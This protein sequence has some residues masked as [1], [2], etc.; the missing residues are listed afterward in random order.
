MQIDLRVLNFN[1]QS[2]KIKRYL[3][4]AAFKGLLSQKY[5]YFNV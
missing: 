3:R 1:E 5:I 2:E 4:R